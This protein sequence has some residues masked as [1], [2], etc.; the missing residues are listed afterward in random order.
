MKRIILFLLLCSLGFGQSPNFFYSYLTTGISSTDTTVTFTASDTTYAGDNTSFYATIWQ[1]NGYANAAEAYKAGKAEIVLVNSRTTN[2]FDIER[3]QLG[4]TARSFNTSGKRYKIQADVY[5]THLFNGASDSIGIMRARIDTSFSIYSH[6]PFAY[7]SALNAGVTRYFCPGY[8]NAEADAGDMRY[9][10]ST[11][12]KVISFTVS[13]NPS[14]TADATY[15]DTWTLM[16]NGSN[17]AMTLSI[18]K[19][20]A[21]AMNYI[22]STSTAG[23]VSFVAGDYFEVKGVIASGSPSFINMVGHIRIKLN[24]AN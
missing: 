13:G 8:Y 2:T 9:Y 3:A 17:T 5:G 6:L 23:S 16:K 19:T 20:V 10:M 11:S 15:A 24:V 22:T 14:D 7:Q 4:T 18:T 1:M 21:G 12:G